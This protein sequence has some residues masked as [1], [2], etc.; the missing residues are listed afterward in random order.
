[1]SPLEKVMLFFE[2]QSDLAAFCMVSRS[3][4]THWKN[5]GGRIT[6]WHAEAISRATG[7]PKSEIC[8]DRFPI[9]N[10]LESAQKEERSKDV[11]IGNG[12]EGAGQGGNVEGQG[13]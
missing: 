12:D 10:G 1:M 3:T 6:V 11:R 9:E 4:V 2:S 5:D 13:H 7:L 8:P